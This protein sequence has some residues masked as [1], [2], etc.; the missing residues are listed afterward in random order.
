MT[1]AEHAGEIV[2]DFVLGLV[3]AVHFVDELVEGLGDGIHVDFA[4]LVHFLGNLV[5]HI[6][7]DVLVSGNQVLLD[8]SECSVLPDL[9]VDELVGDDTHLLEGQG[10]DAG[11]REA[12][13]DPAL[14]FFLEASD[15]LLD[16][17]D[18]DFIVNYLKKDETLQKSGDTYR[19]RSFRSIA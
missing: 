14:G 12:L 6:T 3:S 19:T 4:L 15:F 1:D 5:G 11:S 10:L 9:Q 7:V 17:F 16:E 2:G 8:A 18:H 13:D